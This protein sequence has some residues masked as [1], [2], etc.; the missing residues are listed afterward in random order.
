MTTRKDTDAKILDAALAL[1][2]ENGYRGTTT[3]AV[4]AQAKVN[5]VTI[6]R[7]FGSKE[8][9]FQAVLARETDVRRTASRLDMRPSGDV[10][11]DLAKF[12]KFIAQNMFAKAGLMKL[13]M[14]EAGRDPGLWKQVSHAPFE[15]IDM[16]A[17]YFEGAMRKGLVRRLD[18]EVAAVAFFSF[19]FR[20]MVSRAFLGEDVFIKMDDA[21]IEEFADIFARGVKK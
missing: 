1:F 18:P 5:E 2:V 10:A 9:L 3:R 7:R 20:S 4:A 8:R 13:V 14:L 15:V 11:A 17:A 6:F 19:F 16:L 12:G 21:A